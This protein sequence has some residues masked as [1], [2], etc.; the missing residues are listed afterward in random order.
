MNGHPPA[1]A[2]RQKYFTEYSMRKGLFYGFA[3]LFVLSVSV[4]V[5][6]EPFIPVNCDET[7]TD[8]T[9]EYLNPSYSYYPCRHVRMGRLLF[10][11]PEECDFGRRLVASV[12]L[13]G[14]IGWERRM[15]DRPA[16]IRYETDLRDIAVMMKE[17]F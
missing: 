4:I 9:I 14:V 3:S 16:G 1:H 8:K 11:T 10:L 5:V 2:I 13:G 7:L 12:V 17:L 15:A 6:L